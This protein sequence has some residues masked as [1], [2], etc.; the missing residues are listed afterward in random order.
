VIR[1]LALLPAVVSYTLFALA[2]ATLFVCLS[3]AWSRR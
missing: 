3:S 2:T 1:P